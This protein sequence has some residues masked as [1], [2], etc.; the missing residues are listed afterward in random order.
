MQCKWEVD[1]ICTNDKSPVCAD[2][3]RSIDA[4]GL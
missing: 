3:C 4:P 2:Y 1:E